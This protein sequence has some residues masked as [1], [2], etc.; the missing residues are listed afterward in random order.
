MVEM[1]QMTSVAAFPLWSLQKRMVGSDIKATWKI[2]QGLLTS[3]D[4][5]I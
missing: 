4:I 3:I 1:T 5:T 2:L